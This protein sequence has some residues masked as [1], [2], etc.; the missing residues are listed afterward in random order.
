[1]EERRLQMMLSETGGVP[2]HLA[3]NGIYVLRINNRLYTSDEWD[4]SWN[5]ESVGVAVI[6]DECRFVIAKESGNDNLKWSLDGVYEDVVGILNT[7]D[8]T[9]AKSDY[10]G[11]QNTDKMVAMYGRQGNYSAGYCVTYEFING[12]TGY[13]GSCGEWSVAHK[14]RSTINPLLAK[15]GGKRIGNNDYLWTS[16]QY[17]DA[18]AWCIQFSSVGITSGSKTAKYITRAFCSL[19]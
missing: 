17:D 19:D 4:E 8:K 15:I 12:K 1:M 3:E 14:S 11:I 9:K 5:E 13:L 10:K 16:T 18:D 2:P 7:T 6:T